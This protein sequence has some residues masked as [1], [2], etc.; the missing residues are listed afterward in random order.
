[1][2]QILIKVGGARNVLVTRDAFFLVSF[3]T[4]SREEIAEETEKI[5]EDRKFPLLW[6][7]EV[8]N[9]KELFTRL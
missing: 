3:V 2:V 9:L 7:V 5:T 4:F 8:F 6:V 1:M